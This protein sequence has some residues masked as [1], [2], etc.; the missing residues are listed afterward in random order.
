MSRR[1]TI[2]PGDPHSPEATRLLN[3]SHALMQSL[4]PAKSNHYLSIGALCQPDILFFIARLEGDAAGCAA[5]AL[6]DT[7]AEVKSMF[8]D[9][10]KRGACIG[11]RLLDRLQSEA[12]ARDI[13]ILRLE[14]GDELTAARKLYAAQGFTIC[15]PFGE[16][17]PDRRSLFMEKI[18]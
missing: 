8:V 11:T 18:L 7:Y 2:T 6:K 17:R 4:F 14:T 5:L 16:Y 9:P 1:V 15:P 13:P 12:R 3:A 10:A